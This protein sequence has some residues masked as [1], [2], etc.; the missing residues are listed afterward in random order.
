MKMYIQRYLTD[1][2]INFRLPRL[3]R[4]GNQEKR[5]EFI[6]DF[7][8]SVSWFVKEYYWKGGQGSKRLTIDIE[9]RPSTN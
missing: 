6:I 9:E 7:S 5:E 3:L 2:F 4:L 8:E 1:F